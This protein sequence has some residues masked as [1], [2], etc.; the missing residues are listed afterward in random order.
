[1]AF[2]RGTWT[3]NPAY[4][5]VS[6][7]SPRIDINEPEACVDQHLHG[8]TPGLPGPQTMGQSV[9]ETTPTGKYTTI[10]EVHHCSE[11]T[12]PEYFSRGGKQEF[13]FGCKRKEQP[14]RHVIRNSSLSRKYQR[15]YVSMPSLQITRNARDISKSQEQFRR[16]IPSKLYDGT[17]DSSEISI[18]PECCNDI[19]TQEMNAES[20]IPLVGTQ[21]NC[22]LALDSNFDCVLPSDSQIHAITDEPYIHL[23]PQ[24][25][26]TPSRNFIEDEMLHEWSKEQYCKQRHQG[27]DQGISTSD[28][29]K[30]GYLRNV[31][32]IFVNHKIPYKDNIDTSCHSPESDTL[33]KQDAENDEKETHT[34][35]SGYIPHTHMDAYIPHTHIKGYIPHTPENV[36]HTNTPEYIRHTQTQ[37]YIPHSDIL[38]NN[39]HIQTQEYI[40]NE[41]IRGNSS[42]QMQQR[43]HQ[44][45]QHTHDQRTTPYT[46]VQMYALDMDAQEYIPHTDTQKYTD[47]Q[48]YIPHPDEKGYIPHVDEQGYIAH[49]DEQGYIPHTDNGAQNSSEILLYANS[50]FHMISPG[51]ELVPN[52]EEDEDVTGMRDDAKTVSLLNE[53]IDGACH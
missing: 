50:E 10:S 14:A 31:G 46:D 41:L 22:S 11:N 4:Q 28:V 16:S 27:E 42:E 33:C 8:S 34:H 43:Y 44:Q 26:E 52:S 49:V 5:S 32:V 36:P 7:M 24:D 53:S 51:K 47:E 39:P 2:G 48:G 37:D 19:V 23:M 12:V 20:V 6:M 13:D 15:L 45:C 40:P 9:G 17:V 35:T 3:K 38:G 21:T 25:P 1:M 29:V 30:S 18:K